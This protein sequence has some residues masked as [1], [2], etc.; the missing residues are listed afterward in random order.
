MIDKHALKKIKI[1]RWNLK[2]HF[3]KNFRKQIMTTSCLK[4][5]QIDQKIQVTLSSL[6]GNETWWHI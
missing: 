4:N 3:N 5:K 6:S 2:H 1:L